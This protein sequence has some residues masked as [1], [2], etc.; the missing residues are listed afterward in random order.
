MYNLIK[1]VSFFDVV[2]FIFCFA[3]SRQYS[4]F[5]PQFY[6]SLLFSVIFACFIWV[7]YFKGRLRFLPYSSN[8]SLP[9]YLMFL[10]V[11][12]Y[13]FIMGVWPDN[14]YDTRHFR[15]FEHIASLKS[16]QED[17]SFY[18]LSPN[19]LAAMVFGIFKI[20][21]GMRG[22]L[23]FNVIL[24]VWALYECR[25]IL[26][27]YIKNEKLLLL[28]LAVILY[29]SQMAFI[30]LNVYFVDL[31]SVP[32]FLMAFRLVTR[33]EN[34]DEYAKLMFLSFLLGL[35]FAFKYTNLA[36]IVPLGLVGLFNQ[37]KLIKKNPF[38]LFSGLF[39]IFPNL[40]YALYMWLFFKNP[41]FPYF[42]AV[43]KSPYWAIEDYKIAWSGPKSLIESFLW[44]VMVTWMPERFS[45]VIPF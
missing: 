17:G 32:L 40:P 24:L 34:D 14:S 35:L 41:V 30:Q 10:P 16:F 19:P 15:L 36:F 38:V 26:Y 7:F 28:V 43:F 27:K 8:N 29:G 31:F 42:N 4:F 6:V 1:K 23:I 18:Y 44:P 12:I 21:L 11:I 13:F 9:F 2:F 20:F 45:Q 3:V 39:F 22:A 33:G 37:F 25:E 5:I